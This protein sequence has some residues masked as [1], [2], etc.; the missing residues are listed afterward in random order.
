M[1]KRTKTKTTANSQGKEC[2]LENN[3]TTSLTQRKEKLPTWNSIPS[4]ALEQEKQDD[5]E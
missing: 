2:K 5:D 3:G 4:Q 1:Y